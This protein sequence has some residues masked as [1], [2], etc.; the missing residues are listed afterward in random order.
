M[1]EQTELEGILLVDKPS[2]PTSHDVVDRARRVCRMRRVGHAGTLDPMATGLLV[3]LIGKATKLSQYLTSLDKVYHGS[4]TLGVA[5]NT[6]DAE[7]EVA[8]TKPVPDLAEEEVARAMETFVG[9][10]Y[11]TPPMFSAVKIKGKRLY[12]MARKGQEVEREPRFIRI[13]RFD[14]IEL[15][16]PEIRFELACAKGTYARVL[17]NDFGEKLGCGGHLSQLR[18]I[19]SGQFGVDQAISLADLER[20]GP[21]SVSKIMIPPHDAAPTPLL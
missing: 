1:R 16:L 18:R 21:Q 8:S 2:G 11:Q 4:I 17:A 14:L 3:L 13:S 15:K 7:G 9:D 19:A 12:K 6:M 10:Q 20:L 5:T